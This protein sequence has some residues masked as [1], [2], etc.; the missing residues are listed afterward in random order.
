MTGNLLR[1]R[2][3]YLPQ[4]RAECRERRRITGLRIAPRGNARHDDADSRWMRLGCVG[5]ALMTKDSEFRIPAEISR[6]WQALAERRRDH[7]VELQRSGRWRKYYKE[8]AF[9]GQMHGAMGEPAVWAEIAQ[10][11][12]ATIE[13]PEA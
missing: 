8:E 11:T 13:Q 6:R 3:T 9:L 7:F 12:P 4:R 5:V 1:Q 10:D 2:V